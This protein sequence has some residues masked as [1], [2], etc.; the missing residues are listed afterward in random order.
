MVGTHVADSHVTQQRPLLARAQITQPKS[1]EQLVQLPDPA[2]WGFSS[3]ALLY[4]T[5]RSLLSL[6]WTTW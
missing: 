5:C 2:M 6:P 4:S 1:T 3:P